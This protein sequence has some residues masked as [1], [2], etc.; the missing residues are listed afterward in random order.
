MANRCCHLKGAWLSGSRQQLRATHSQIF[1]PPVNTSL[2]VV[3]KSWFFPLFGIQSVSDIV[4]S[5][6]IV[7]A[8]ACIIELQLHIHLDLLLHWWRQPASCTKWLP[9]VP[10]QHRLQ[11][12]LRPSISVVGRGAISCYLQVMW[13]FTLIVGNAA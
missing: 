5:D 13:I 11:T 6:C 3:S 9:V 2:L 4:F 7:A 10:P 8:V 12:R 1:R